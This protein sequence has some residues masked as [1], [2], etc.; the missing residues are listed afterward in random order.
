MSKENN[1]SKFLGELEPP[2]NLQDRVVLNIRKLELAQDRKKAV[3]F[4]FG[5]LISVSATIFVAV[6]S[7]GTFMQSEFYH[8]LSIIFSGD[9]VLAYWKE[10]S[11]SLVESLPIFAVIS[12]LIAVTVSLWSVSNTVTSVR[13]IVLAA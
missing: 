4:G 13:K 1:I 11:L 2:P 9:N 10:L 12:L 3:M 5:A 8:Y 6:T 7:L